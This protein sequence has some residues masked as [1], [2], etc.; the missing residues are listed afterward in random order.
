MNIDSI[1]NLHTCTSCQMCA[2]VCP[3]NAITISLDDYGF[4]RPNVNYDK[5]IDCS[6]C[7]KYCYKFDK[8]IASFDIHE[9]KQSKLYAAYVKDMDILSHTTSGGV[10][11]VLSHY[12]YYAGYKCI[13][14]IYDSEN[15]IAKSIVANDEYDLKSFRGSKYIQ[16]YTLNAL[17]DLINGCKNEKYAIFGTPCHIYAIHKYLERYN[18]RDNHILIDLY[19]HGCPSMNLWKKYLSGLRSNNCLNEETSYSVN[20]RSK[21]HGWGRFAIEFSNN[22]KSKFVSGKTNDK[23][24]N[25]FFSDMLLNKACHDCKLRDTLRYTDFRLGDFW[26]K[27]YIFNHNGVS[28]VSI[29]TKNAEKVFKQI[30]NKLVFEEKSYESFLNWQSIG[31]DIHP[32]PRT[33]HILLN[34]LKTNDTT[35]KECQMEYMKSLSAVSVVKKSAKNVLQHLPN[36]IISFIKYIYY[37]V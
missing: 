32:D 31:K 15:D 16:S 30:E 35:I 36:S 14:V 8:D 13:G 20:F 1:T 9:I 19:C 24:F 18:I 4:Y 37:K 12:L 11:D 33:R 26:G 25:L 3:K 29:V 34:M 17:K 23:F 27:E 7:T 28:A 6:I 2:A 22:N 5:C 10:A 21:S